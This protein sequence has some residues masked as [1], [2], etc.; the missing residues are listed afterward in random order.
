MR[1]VKNARLLTHQRGANHSV[2]EL[3]L[4]T[5]TTG[6][7]A[8]W[9]G[10]FSAVLTNPHAL[11]IRTKFYQNPSS[12]LHSH[13]KSTFI[14]QWSDPW[15]M[16]GPEIVLLK[17]GRILLKWI[18]RRLYTCCWTGFTS[19]VIE[20]RGRLFWI[21]KWRFV[22][23]KVKELLNELK[24]YQRSKKDWVTSRLLKACALCSIRSFI[25]MYEAGPSG[26]AF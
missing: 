17:C 19:L 9:L 7:S 20:F 13:H 1:L 2:M 16:A 10:A 8:V 3:L 23:H 26:R 12:A 24:D 18:L 15:F 22:L 14:S 25:T 6:Q 5:R 21:R 4:I 11:F